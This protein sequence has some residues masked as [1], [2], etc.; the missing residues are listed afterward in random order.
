MNFDE[1]DPEFDITCRFLRP[2]NDLEMILMQLGKIVLEIYIHL[3][4]VEFVCFFL[5]FF[6]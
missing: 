3:L 1:I 4:H 2:L 6:L 5:A